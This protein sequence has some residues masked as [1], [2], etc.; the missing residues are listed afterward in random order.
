MRTHSPTFFPKK[1]KKIGKTTAKI[2]K[3]KKSIQLGEEIFK[4]G[5]EIIW[6][7]KYAESGKKY[8]II[9]DIVDGEL[10]GRTYQNN[11]EFHIISPESRN[12][13]KLNNK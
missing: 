13:K 8:G 1:V 6:D 9:T 5:D 2:E 3:M 7:N 12:I 4:I 11:A 10:F